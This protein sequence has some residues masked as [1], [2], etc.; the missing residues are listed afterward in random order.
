MQR[1][2]DAQL[3]AH[4][5]TSN[6]E[7]MDLVD[8]HRADEQ[9]VGGGPLR[10]HRQPGE[11]ARRDCAARFRPVKWLAVA[12]HVNGGVSAQL[13]AEANDDQAAENLRGVLNG[14]ISLARLQGQ[15]DPK[16]TSLINSL[17]LTGRRQDGQALVLGAGRD[18]RTDAAEGA[19]GGAL[20]LGA[21]RLGTRDSDIEAAGWIQPAVF[22]LA[23]LS[24]APSPEPRARALRRFPPSVY[25]FSRAYHVADL[26]F[27]YG[28]L[29][30]GFDRRRRAGIDD[31][32]TYV[33]RGAIHAALFDVGLYPAAVPAP[34]ALVWGEV[35][36]MR[37]RDTV[38][39]ALDEIEGY[40]VDDPDRSLYLRQE[41][42]VRLPDGTFAK[43]SVYFY[44]APL[45]RA[46]RIASGDYLEH[47][48]A[49]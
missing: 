4:S 35:Y 28:T 44:N 11:A 29:M 32:L 21:R 17:Q 18:L 31:K 34:E 13:R 9:R 42:D 15:N 3:S 26:V 37:D 41:T 14:V 5:I 49:R 30:A 8:R 12:G 7:M 19:A 25:L 16:L 27:F 1:A 6:N 23:V 38:L 45:G 20:E 2:I 47:V 48:R 43:A 46:P 10:P 40:R 24:R 22:F 36:A 39:A 33:G